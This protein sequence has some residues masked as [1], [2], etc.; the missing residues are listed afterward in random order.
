MVKFFVKI[1][2]MAAP[3]AAEGGISGA[4]SDAEKEL[5][6]LLEQVFMGNRTIDREA[7]CVIPGVKV[8][9]NPFGSAVSHRLYFYACHGRALPVVCLSG[10]SCKNVNATWN[11]RFFSG[12]SPASDVSLAV[13]PTCRI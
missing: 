10:R 11:A 1:S 6:R 9:V 7:L 3:R 4:L 5:L 13:W 8:R 12:F 2:P